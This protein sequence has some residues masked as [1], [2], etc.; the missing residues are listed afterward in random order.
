M[1]VRAGL[2]FESLGL[3]VASESVGIKHECVLQDLAGAL[4]ALSDPRL[5]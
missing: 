2:V 5:D 1:S 3:L 4:K